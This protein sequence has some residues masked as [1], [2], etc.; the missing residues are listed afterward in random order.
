MIFPKFLEKNDCIGITALSK[1]A[2]DVLKEMKTSINHLKKDYRLIIT[3]NVYNEG[4]VSSDIKTRIKEFNTLLDEDIKLLMNIRGGDF[5]YE[6]LDGLDYTK[7]VKKKIW[8]QGYSDPTSLLY[9]L[10]TKYD[11]ATIYGFNGK[12][13][14]SEVLE[15]YQINNL[16]ILKGNI[17]KQESF[18]DRETISLNGDFQSK[19]II[20]GGCLDVLK[21]LFGTDYDHTLSFLQKYHQKHI[22]WYFDIFAMNSVDVYL[23]ILQMKKMGYFE[24]SDTFIFGSVL[25]PNIE[26]EMSYCDAFAKALG[27]KNIIVD[28]N[29]GHVKPC[30]TIINGSLA[31]VQYERNRM[32]L[33]M[34][35]GNESDG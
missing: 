6:T 2:G 31:K 24:Y 5:L 35:L 34:E 14:D 30:F 18:M 19:G 10:T 12:S 16:K 32:V 13:Y 11:L 1:G 3:P 25:F 29:I 8:V 26:C 22:I 33:E 15:P 21:N 7:L 4:Y 23:T 28:A 17:V 20:I 27:K 9:L